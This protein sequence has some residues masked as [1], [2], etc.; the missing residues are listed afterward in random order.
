MDLDRRET[1]LRIP[2]LPMLELQAKYRRLE[3]LASWLTG[4]A[5]GLAITVILRALQ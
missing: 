2:L 1:S 3:T 5:L 4:S